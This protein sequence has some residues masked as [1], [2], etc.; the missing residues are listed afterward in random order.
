MFYLKGGLSF[1]TFIISFFAF[2]TD[3]VFKREKEKSLLA[4]TSNN[5]NKKVLSI[6]SLFREPRFILVAQIL[7]VSSL[8]NGFIEPSI[9]IHLD[10]VINNLCF[11][12]SKKKII[13]RSSINIASTNTRRTR[14][15]SFHS[16]FNL[17]YNN[18]IHWPTLW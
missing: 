10:P 3:E 16:I 2:P 15:N 7:F 14:S 13:K 1:L 17:Y 8:S 9:Q 5:H 6:N 12:I 4:Q 11:K 18:T